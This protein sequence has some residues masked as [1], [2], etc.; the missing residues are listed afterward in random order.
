MQMADSCVQRDE[1]VNQR[2]TK[3]GDEVFQRRYLRPPVQHGGPLHDE[4]PTDGGRPGVFARPDV[5]E[6][7]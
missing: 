7:V 4:I 5:A 6:H 3:R 2:R 1:K